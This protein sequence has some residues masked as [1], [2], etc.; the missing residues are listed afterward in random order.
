MLHR[1]NYLGSPLFFLGEHNIVVGDDIGVNDNDRIILFSTP[2][3]IKAASEVS[4][5]NIDCTFKE[6]KYDSFFIV[7]IKAMEDKVDWNL[8]GAR[9][10]TRPR[11]VCPSP[12][13]TRHRVREEAG[14]ASRTRSQSSM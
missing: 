1:Y 7:I 3:Q 9:P 11:P 8:Y 4:R 13:R 10:R 2:A 6:L 5:L 14:P 12:A